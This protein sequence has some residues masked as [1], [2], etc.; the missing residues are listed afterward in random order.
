MTIVKTHRGAT[1]SA[2]ITCIVSLSGCGMMGD[3][4]SIKSANEL[5]ID[6]RTDQA[7]AALDKAEKS[8]GMATYLAGL[9]RIGI[10]RD[11][12]RTEEA[13]SAMQAYLS[14][15][16]TSSTTREE[17]DASIDKFIEDLRQERLEQTGRAMCP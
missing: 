10:L 8:G 1:T 2:I 13:D 17:I 12:G 5:A 7:L 14:R 4:G 16:E 11:V 15:P 9:E 3:T 6:C